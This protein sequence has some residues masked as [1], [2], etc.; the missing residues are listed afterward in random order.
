MLK[1]YSYRAYPG[2]SQQRALSR[3]FGCVRLTYN[4]AIAEA[5]RCHE[6]GEGYP[7]ATELQK[8]VLTRA[9]AERPFL[10]EVCGVALVQAVRDA[11]RAYRNFFTSVKGTRKGRKVGSPKFR[12]RHDR[13]QS[14]R[15]TSATSQGGLRVR[16]VSGTQWAEVWVPKVGWL[17]YRNSR[18]LPSQPTSA[19]IIGNPDGTFAISFVVDAPAPVA[20][21]TG[22][23]SA[24]DLGLTDLATIVNSDG[25]REKVAAPKLLRDSERRL[26][27]RQR[28][29]AR[30]Q[31]GSANREKAHLRVARA[32]S[33]VTRQRLDLAHKLST[34][35]ARE[36]QAVAVES[37]SITGL[38][39][40]RLAKSVHDAGWGILLR[41]LAEKTT[42]VAIDRWCPSTRTCSQCGVIGGKR[43]LHIREWTCPDCGAWL[44]RDYNAAVNIMVAAG[45]AETQ[46]ACGGDV[47]PKL[48][49]MALATADPGEAGTHRTDRGICAPAA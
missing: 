37:L 42:V 49:P 32:H 17:R 14:A 1:R 15:L 18:P 35:L 47:R 23:V 20:P 11:D 33:R 39:R 7:G 44:D 31:K 3:L 5:R 45:L 38:A 28:E 22:C 40:T 26:A 2:V 34:R 30:K 4:S 13:R 9:K 36:N 29:L 43:P 21:A 25:T 19:T 12:S 10:T 27:K 8:R 24:I 41:L 46:N 16:E 6:A 48:M